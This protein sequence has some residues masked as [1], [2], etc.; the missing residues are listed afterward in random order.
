MRGKYN[1][2]LHT[3]VFWACYAVFVCKRAHNK[4][5]EP[6][7][8]RIKGQAQSDAGEFRNNNNDNH[9]NY[10]PTWNILSIKM[11]MEEK[12]LNTK[13]WYLNFGNPIKEQGYEILS[14]EKV[15]TLYILFLA[16]VCRK[17]LSGKAFFLWKSLE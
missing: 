2:S 9:Y 17:F 13:F 15:C 3:R 16:F 1:I 6:K 11:P 4:A 7:R 14:N 8:L 10:S 5:W 12:I